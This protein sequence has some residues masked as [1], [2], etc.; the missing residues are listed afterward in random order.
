[1]NYTNTIYNK[2][3]F[4]IITKQGRVYINGEFGLSTSDLSKQKYS[5]TAKAIKLPLFT[6]QL[7]S[8]IFKTRLNPTSAINYA[9]VNS[10]SN[11]V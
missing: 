5:T 6:N 4:V 1:M 9:I 2:D 11:A 10:T 7:N 3:L 8:Y